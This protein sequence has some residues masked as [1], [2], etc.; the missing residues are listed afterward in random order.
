MTRFLVAGGTLL[1]ISA[2]ALVARA[3]VPG[4]EAEAVTEVAQTI[5]VSGEGEA[6]GTPEVAMVSLSVQNEGRTA[7]EAIDAN[8]AAMA[9][10]VEAMKRIG[11]PE[12]GLR[13]SGI[14]INPVRARQQPG[15]S[16]PPPI[17][18]YQAVNSLTVTVEPAVKAGEVIDVGIGAGANVAG[19]VRFAMKDDATLQ[20]EALDMAVKSARGKADAMAAAAGLRIVGVRT[21][22]EEGGPGVPVVRA[23]A[24]GLAAAD[25]RQVPPVQPGEL[26]L[27]TRVRVVYNFA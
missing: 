26:T 11:V 6:S 5:T 20:K 1:V 19:G 21:M 2:L 12:R 27:R 4:V 23:E 22:T 17:V 18:G 15:E 10:V 8:S 9:Q 14:S 25:A 3:V 24:Q 7:R 16:Q 13:T